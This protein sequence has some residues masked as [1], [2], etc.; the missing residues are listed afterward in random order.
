MAAL[1]P[2]P[3]FGPLGLNEIRN[4]A[5]IWIAIDSIERRR[6]AYNEK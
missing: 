5:H 3:G 4:P 2:G 1:S 6:Y